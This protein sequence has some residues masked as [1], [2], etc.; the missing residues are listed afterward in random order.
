M[1]IFTS[2]LEPTKAIDVQPTT[3]NDQKESEKSGSA[4]TTL[5]GEL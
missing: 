1:E 2:C 4:F 3:M 5:I